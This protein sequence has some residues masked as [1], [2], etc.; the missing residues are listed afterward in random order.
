MKGTYW[1]GGYHSLELFYYTYL[2]GNLMVHEKPVTLYYYIEPVDT[3]RTISLKPVAL[4][5]N[6]LTIEKITL[7]GKKYDKFI[8][9]ICE[10][11]IPAH[12]GGEFKVTFKP[13][14]SKF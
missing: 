2:Y 7:N 4:G 10:L 13:V 12:E 14:K 9:S 5:E 8:G 3:D 6:I 1:K 11:Q